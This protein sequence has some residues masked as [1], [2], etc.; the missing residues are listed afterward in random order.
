MRSLQK[1]ANQRNH[2]QNKYRTPKLEDVSQALLGKGK[3]GSGAISGANVHS[4]TIDQQKQYVLQDAQLVMD[5]SKA[6]NGQIMSVMQAISK[7][8]GLGLEQVCHSNLSTWWT[9]GFDDRDAS[10]HGLAQG[11]KIQ[12]NPLIIKA[13]L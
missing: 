7:L 12:A 13:V 3:H 4:L 9:K 6:N 5:L 2:L 8:T 10:L 11:R 1:G